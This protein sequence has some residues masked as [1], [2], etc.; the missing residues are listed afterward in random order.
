MTAH[1]KQAKE[2]LAKRI[3]MTYLLTEIYKQAINLLTVSRPS[4]CSL[5]AGHQ[6]VHCKQAIKLFTESR[7]QTCLQRAGQ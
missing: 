4:T 1:C 5:Q 7:T 6:P 3:P 2:L